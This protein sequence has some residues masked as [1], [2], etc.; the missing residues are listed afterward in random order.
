MR[1]TDDSQGP[2][3]AEY[4]IPF[5]RHE[6]IAG[7]EFEERAPELLA[8]TSQCVRVFFDAAAAGN[9]KLAHEAA[10]VALNNLG[11]LFDDR[12]DPG[13]MLVAH[14]IRTL[15]DLRRGMADVRMA[16]PDRK[17]LLQAQRARFR[18]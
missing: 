11:G 8:M 17:L 2:E 10:A 9:T 15:F 1:M 12:E 6:D 18:S 4:D 5:A 7:I 16:T 14:L 13:Y 3:G